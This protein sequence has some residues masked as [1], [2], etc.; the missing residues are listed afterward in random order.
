MISVL[1]LGGRARI[2][3]SAGPIPPA[4]GRVPVFLDFGHKESQYFVILRDV[5]ADVPVNEERLTLSTS[6]RAFSL[7]HFARQPAYAVVYRLHR[8]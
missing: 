6:Y 5:T 1:G 7:Y 3:E 4:S 8:L 2:V